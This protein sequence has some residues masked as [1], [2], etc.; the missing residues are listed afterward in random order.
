MDM[1]IDELNMRI[2]NAESFIIANDGQFLGKLSLNIYDS[3]S[4]SN[5]YGLYG[6]PY[7][8]VSIKNKYSTYGSRYS[9]LSPFN[10]YT[11]TPPMI[12][13]RGI[14]YGYLSVNKFLYRSVD[15]NQIEDWMKNNVLFY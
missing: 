14:K 6:S 7:S 9:S 15:P 12:Y 3:T 13:L 2:R 4:I 1:K 5:K 10:P 8:A 11:I